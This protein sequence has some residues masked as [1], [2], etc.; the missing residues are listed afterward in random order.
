M[1]STTVVGGTSGGAARVNPAT[2][3]WAR[4]QQGSGHG[5]NGDHAYGTKSALDIP[6]G[7]D[8]PRKHN[9]RPICR[10]PGNP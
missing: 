7:W 3:P 5:G 8:G 9:C 4:P 10:G 6:P 1:S 2:N